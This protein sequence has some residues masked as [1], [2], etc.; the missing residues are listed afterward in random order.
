LIHLQEPGTL[1]EPKSTYSAIEELEAT[2]ETGLDAESLDIDYGQ[3][4]K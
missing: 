3:Q 1:Q 2:M 4:F